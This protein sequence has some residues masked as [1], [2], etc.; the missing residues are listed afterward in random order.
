MKRLLVLAA[1]LLAACVTSTAPPPVLTPSA[2][3]AATLAMWTAT[4]EAIWQEEL[5]RAIDPGGLTG[6]LGAAQAGQTAVIIRAGVDASPEHAAYLER[7]KVP[8]VTRRT[9]IV[10][11][12]G[13][14]VVDD[15][16]TFHPL[17][18]SFLWGLYGEKFERDRVT[19]H[20]QF[21]APYK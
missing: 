21:L 3:S 1:L 8:A 4:C 20:L 13:R 5:G 10:R 12:V 17:G 14:T 15:G 19:A 6:C 16:G 7:L 9:G 2:P 11:A 18:I